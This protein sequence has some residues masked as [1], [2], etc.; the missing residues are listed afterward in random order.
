MIFN[1][2]FISGG[3]SK[4]WLEVPVE[5][6]HHIYFYFNE[7]PVE[8]NFIILI[9]D[10]DPK[11]SLCTFVDIDQQEISLPD[12]TYYFLT[13]DFDNGVIDVDGGDRANPTSAHFL[14]D[15]GISL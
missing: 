7:L 1:P 10:E 6:G 4:Q 13:L 8:H 5:D 14:P 9:Q 2:V 15:V 11:K 3:D 12:E